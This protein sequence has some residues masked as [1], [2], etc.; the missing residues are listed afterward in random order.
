MV[1][2]FIITGAGCAGSSFIHYLLMN[3]KLKNKSILIIDSIQS[4]LME[5]SWCYWAEKPYS[6]Q[7]KNTKIIKWNKLRLVNSEGKEVIKKLNNLSYFQVNS[8]AFFCERKNEQSSAQ[9][10][11]YINSTVSYINEKINFTEVASSDGKKYIGKQVI[12]SIP[13]FANLGN[14]YNNGLKQV[15]VG[16][17]VNSSGLNFDTSCASLM[18][19][20]GLPQKEVNFMYVLPISKKEALIEY[21]LFTKEN[22]N[23]EALKLSL[24]NI[25]KTKYGI[26]E[27]EILGEEFGIIPMSTLINPNSNSDKIFHIGTAGGATKATTGYTFKNIQKQCKN[28]V[29]YFAG[30]YQKLPNIL[31]NNR[32]KFYDNILLNLIIKWPKQLGV[33]FPAMFNNNNPEKIL[34]FLDEETNFFEEVQIFVNLP[35]KYFIKSLFSYEKH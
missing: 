5:K 15:F 11:T 31:N 33:I 23:L 13:K 20:N 22:L 34:R 16:F 25:I 24:K 12:N 28:L 4:Q 30:E 1:Y 6:V 14:A 3:P 32:F 2:D 18:D 21:T 19:F 10:I 27:Y 8:K 26:R 9:N 17:K 29:D 7:P 35:K